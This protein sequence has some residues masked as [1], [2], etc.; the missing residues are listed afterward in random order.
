MSTIDKYQR[1]TLAPK[2]KLSVEVRRNPG[3]DHTELYRE[4]RTR[5]LEAAIRR[6][7]DG[8]PAPNAEQRRELAAILLDGSD[9]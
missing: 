2:V 6:T 9:A 8:I 3:G 7:L 1:L 4:L 5:T